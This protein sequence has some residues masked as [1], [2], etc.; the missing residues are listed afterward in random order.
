MQYTDS[1][2]VTD[3]RVTETPNYGRNADGYGSK[4]PTRYM[5]K[6]A[7]RWRRVYVMV[8]SNSGSA[9]VVVGGQDLFLDTDTEY[10]LESL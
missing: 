2:L 10:K 7:G 6:Y 9:Y 5:V 8:Y 4:I 3:F 1:E